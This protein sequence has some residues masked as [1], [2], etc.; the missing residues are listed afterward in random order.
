MCRHPWTSGIKCDIFIEYCDDPTPVNGSVNANESPIITGYYY[1]GIKVTFMC[2][3]GY[4]LI[5]SKSSSCNN[6]NSWIPSPPTCIQGNVT[7]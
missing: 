1:V 3:S 2:Y 5:G 6:G 7:N 4:T